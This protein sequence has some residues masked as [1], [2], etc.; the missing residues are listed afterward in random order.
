MKCSDDQRHKTGNYTNLLDKLII[1]TLLWTLDWNLFWRR[2]SFFT[3]N[4][5]FYH[6]A[7]VVIMEDSN[8]SGSR[9]RYMRAAV[10]F[11]P[12]KR[13]SF[14]FLFLESS[15][16]IDLTLYLFAGYTPNQRMRTIFFQHRPNTLIYKSFLLIGS[17]TC[18]KIWACSKWWRRRARPP[19]NSNFSVRNFLHIS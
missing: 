7:C 15:K 18:S 2:F 8:Q 19:L 16:S 10:T 5:S 9:R 13:I 14:F 4:K 6:S 12:R 17:L 11:N 1:R 3:S